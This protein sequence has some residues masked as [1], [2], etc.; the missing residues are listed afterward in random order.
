M[1]LWRMFLWSLA[2]IAAPNLPNIPGF[3]PF[4]ANIAGRSSN[5][6]KMAAPL[7]TQPAPDGRAIHPRSSCPAVTKRDM[8]D[9]LVVAMGAFP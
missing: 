6:G 1:F 9:P 5:Y 8:H 3:V 7:A 4:F 2:D